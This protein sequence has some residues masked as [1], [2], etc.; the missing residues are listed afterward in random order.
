L[1]HPAE[2]AAGARLPTIAGLVLSILM[3]LTVASSAVLPALSV[4]LPL[5]V[6]D[7]F[8]PSVVTVPPDTWFVA[9]PDRL[10]AQSNDTVTSV[11]FQPAALAAGVLLPVSTGF[12]LSMLMPLTVTGSATLPA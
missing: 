3:L 4:Q 5:L 2:F 11:L 8:C 10:S 1:F 12:V 7:W 6:T 9:M